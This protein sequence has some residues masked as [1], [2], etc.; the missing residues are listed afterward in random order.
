MAMTKDRIVVSQDHETHICW[1]FQDEPGI[2]FHD[3]ILQTTAAR[4]LLPHL[5]L[6]VGCKTFWRT[7]P[8]ECETNYVDTQVT[9]LRE[10]MPMIPP[11]WYGAA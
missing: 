9:T 4:H 1:V 7:T 6:M 3:F 11:V 8:M 2:W 5:L 10:P